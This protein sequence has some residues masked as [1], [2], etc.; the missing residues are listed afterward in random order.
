M[1]ITSLLSLRMAHA[2]PICFEF[3]QTTLNI[4]HNNSCDYYNISMYC[5]QWSC[6]VYHGVFLHISK[7]LAQLKLQI[8][9]Q[10]RMTVCNVFYKSS[11][12]CLQLSIRQSISKLIHFILHVVLT[13]VTN[14]RKMSSSRYVAWFTVI[15]KLFFIVK[16]PNSITTKLWR[17]LPRRTHIQV[18]RILLAM[19]KLVVFCQ[20]LDPILCL[21]LKAC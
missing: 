8:A 20:V 11:C 16:P 13:S 4:K 18:P 10:L 2:A 17:P 6:F 9:L 3:L 15:I 1:D 14:L 21:F 7:G 19:F 12:L 5:N